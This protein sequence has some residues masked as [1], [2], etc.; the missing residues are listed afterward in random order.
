MGGKFFWDCFMKCFYFASSLEIGNNFPSMLWAFLHCISGS[1]STFKNSYII[2]L[3]WSFPLPTSTQP[4]S[5]LL[6]SSLS[7][8]LNFTIMYLVM[9]LLELL[10]NSILIEGNANH[11]YH[12]LNFIKWTYWVTSTYIKKQ[13]TT[14][15]LISTAAYP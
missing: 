10:R 6:I 11:K 12:L 3:A 15:S 14:K 8:V 9:E 13:N 4:H 7:L 2:F 1:N 5:K